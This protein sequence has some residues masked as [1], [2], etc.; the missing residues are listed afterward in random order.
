M[1]TT[2]QSK[3]PDLQLAT[4]RADALQTAIHDELVARGFTT[5]EDKVMAEY[6][7]IM[8]INKK[9]PGG[10]VLPTNSLF[11]PLLLINVHLGGFCRTGAGM[12]RREQVNSELSDF[13]GPETWDPTF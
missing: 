7:L 2:R 3:I 1:A 10:F 13:I 11:R 4:P 8:L 9:T 6:V 12:E 5:G